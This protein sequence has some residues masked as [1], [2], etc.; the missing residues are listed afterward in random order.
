MRL[1]GNKI[2][3]LPPASTIFLVVV[4]QDSKIAINM[5]DFPLIDPPGT[6][7]SPNE[8]SLAEKIGERAVILSPMSGYSDLPYRLICRELGSAA[9]I[10]EFVSSE[11]ILRRAGRSFEMLRFDPAER[12][13]IFQIFGHKE[14]S[15]IEA[16]KMIQELG[17]DGIDLNMGCSVRKVA[18][19]G[20]G[21]ALLKEPRKV[22]KIIRALVKEIGL[23]ISAKIRLG[24][25]WQ[26][27]NHI[28]IGK[29]LEGEGAWGVFVHGRTK[30]MAYTGEADWDKIGELK[31][32]LS[33][34]VYG[35][36]DITSR[37]GAL[38]K[39]D[40]YGLDGVLIGRAAMGNP[41]IFSGRPL[42]EITYAERLPVILRHLDLICDF[43]GEEGGVILFRKHV[44]KY[45]KYLF[46]AAE[47]KR[48]L[49]TITGK[50]E[51]VGALMRFLQ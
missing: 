40:H 12:P 2:T 34:K 48:E 10:S 42:R 47:L 39:I 35:N 24:W 23:P 38:E 45:L 18:G 6:Q 37:A 41:W 29:I 30:S 21:A 31:Q 9:S 26:S 36:G 7:K 3:S 46:D 11:A 43:Y 1:A 27:I 49:M 19:K 15:I 25:D 4:S 33:I 32:A 17:P 5:S 44:V 20:A 14:E 16:A 13:V 51:L 8:R 28:E 22:Q 50:E